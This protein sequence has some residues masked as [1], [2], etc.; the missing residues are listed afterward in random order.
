MLHMRSKA[1]L[2]QQTVSD[3]LK[4][5]KRTVL[6]HEHDLNK[7][8]RATV[9]GYSRL[10]SCSWEWLLTGKETYSNIEKPVMLVQAPAE[11]YTSDLKPEQGRSQALHAMLDVVLSSDDVGLKEAFT[12]ILEQ[13]VLITRQIRRGKS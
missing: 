7:P 13:I 10:Y 2:S 4:I 11:E 9:E 5:T 3:V 1:G 6:N 12:V 8:N